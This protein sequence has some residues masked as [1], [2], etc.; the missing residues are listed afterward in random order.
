MGRTI[1]TLGM[2]IGRVLLFLLVGRLL[3][4]LLGGS[5]YPLGVQLGCVCSP[6]QLAWRAPR[7]PFL[8]LR[9]LVRVPEYPV[10]P[11]EVLTVVA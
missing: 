6:V 11:E 9:L 2:D 5:V 10:G 3:S 7:A 4:L 8:L 1:R